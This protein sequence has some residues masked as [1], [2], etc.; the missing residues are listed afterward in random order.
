[1]TEIIRF[2]LYRPQSLEDALRYL[3]DMGE[4]AAPIAGGTEI[5]LLIRDRKIK[6]PKVLVDLN[7]LKK[8]LSY[9]R[10]DGD[11]IRIG[12]LTTIA[13]FEDTILHK[14]KRYAGFVDVYHKF[15][16]P[17]MRYEATIGG[18]IMSATQYND[19]ITIGLVYNARV[20]LVSIN[21]E[22]E[23]K[24]EDFIIDKRKT[25]KRPDELLT[26]I[27]IEKAADNASSA[28]IKFDRRSL[29]IAGIV[30]AAAYLELE[31]DTIR[32][33]RIAF[34]MVKKRVPGRAYETEKFLRGK[35]LTIDTIKEAAY[36]VLP[37]EMT[38]V[39]D[40]WTTAEYRMDMS[41]VALKRALLK[42][43]ERIKG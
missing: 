40:W 29:L 2:N 38:R 22:R 32:D 27:I 37:K 31:G 7:P 14:D 8:Q 42:A 25:A 3:A 35:Q 36:N 20:K 6:T 28:F 10:E 43:A 16:T 39:T 21:G 41:R 1:M 12:A 23:M 34:D 19:Y 13:D 30:T 24:L 11:V 15:A 18:N 4:E 26:E 17:A 5:L 33:V 9:V